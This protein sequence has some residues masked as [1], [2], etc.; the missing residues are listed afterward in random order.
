ML[1][2]HGPQ[3]Y[4]ASYIVKVF[5]DPRSTYEHQTNERIAE[6]T[7]KSMMYLEIYYPE[8]VVES[9]LLENLDKFQIKE[10]V[11]QRHDVKQK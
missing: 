2:K 9:Q 5:T 4:H 3:F 11:I 8:N 1:Y 7:K 10:I 6:T